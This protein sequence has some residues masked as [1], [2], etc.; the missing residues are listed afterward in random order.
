ML[1]SNKGTFIYKAVKQKHKKINSF[2]Q[3]CYGFFFKERV[4]LIDKKCTV[5]SHIN[6]D[7]A[8]KSMCSFNNL[9]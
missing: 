5:T 9:F 1:E 4:W 8:Y 3:K 6:N 2:I 7:Y